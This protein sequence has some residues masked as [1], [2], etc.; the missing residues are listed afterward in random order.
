LCE[1]LFGS[2]A[3]VASPKNFGHYARTT[4]AF[5]RH[6]MIHIILN[7]QARWECFVMTPN[8]PDELKRILRT[9]YILRRLILL[10]FIMT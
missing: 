4:I 7:T 10:N 3:I 6:A 2:A 5:I 9:E 8:L 1:F